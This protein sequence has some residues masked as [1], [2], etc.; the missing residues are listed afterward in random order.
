VFH[1]I[2][3]KDLITTASVA[4]F[5][6]TKMDAKYFDKRTGKLTAEECDD[7]VTSHLARGGAY[8]QA[9]KAADQKSRAIR[10]IAALG[11]VHKQA[12]VEATLEKAISAGCRFFSGSTDTSFFEQVAWDVF[13]VCVRPDKRTIV[14]VV[15]TDTD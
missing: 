10:T 13:V 8:S 6:K 5:L 11:G 4:E 3:S 9:P 2:S 7:F 12:T 1:F 15:C 14:V